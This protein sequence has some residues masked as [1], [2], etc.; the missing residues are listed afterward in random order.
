MIVPIGEDM[1]S[2]GGEEIGGRPF[3]LTS[4]QR[5]TLLEHPL[6]RQFAWIHRPGRDSRMYHFQGTLKQLALLDGYKIKYEA[7]FGLNP[8]ETVVNDPELGLWYVSA[9]D[10]GGHFCGDISRPTNLMNDIS[11]AEELPKLPGCGPL[12]G[13]LSTRGWHCWPCQKFRMLAQNHMTRGDNA[14]DI[15]NLAYGIWSRCHNEK[16]SIWYC[17][18]ENGG[19]VVFFSCGRA[20]HNRDHG[21]AIR[22][23]PLQKLLIESSVDKVVEKIGG[24]AINVD[25]LLSM[26]GLIT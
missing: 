16:N 18:P 26:L 3:M 21:L 4:E 15:R 23:S 8:Y 11:S 14:Q 5:S 19:L 10:D 6:L 20:Y 24:M 1:L 25:K 12:R 22:S 7:L 17:E 13:V 9:G 2:K